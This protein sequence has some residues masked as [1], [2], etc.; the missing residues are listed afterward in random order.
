LHKKERIIMRH[1]KY[2]LTKVFIGLT[3]LLFFLNLS[4]IAVGQDQPIAKNGNWPQFRGYRATGVADAKG[5]PVVWDAT[6]GINI[7]WK[8]DIPGLGHSSPVIWGDQVFI[9]TA[10]GQDNQEPYLRVGL[11]GESPDNPEDYIH[12]YKLYCL[13]KKTGKILWEKTAVSAIP[14]VMR[15]IKGSHATPSP[16]TDGTHV[17]VFFGSQGLYCYDMKGN[18]LWEKDL[19][20]LDAGAFN[21]TNI[22]WGFGSSPIIYKERV[23]TLCDVNNQSFIAAHDIKTGEEIWKTLREEVP[24]WGTPTIVEVNGK[25]QIVVNGWHH[26]GAY[27][28]ETGEEIWKMDGGGDIPVPTPFIA[29]GMLFFSSAHGRQRPIYA[30]NPAAKGDI[31]LDEGA[32]SNEYVTW[33]NPRIGSYIPTPLVY[34]DL[35]YVL[36]DNAVLTTYN[37]KTGE[38]VYRERAGGVRGS[39]S[40]SAVAAE[41]K[42]YCPTEYGNIHV[43]EAG[44]KY[45][46]LSTNPMGEICMATPAIS[47]KTIFIRT[48]KAVYAVEDLG[49]KMTGITSS[50]AASEVD[51]EAE[52][53]SGID[54]ELLKP[55]AHELTDPT[56]ILRRT[57]AASKAVQAVSYDATLVGTGAL[58]GRAGWLSVHII[59]KGYL[60]SLPEYFIVKGKA[61]P[62]GSPDTLYFTGGTNGDKYYLT[63]HQNKSI[64]S[65][66]DFSIMGSYIRAIYGGMI[67]EYHVDEPFGA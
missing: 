52:Q 58:E 18:L 48:H 31:T 44:S 37:A 23:I 32:T 53:A 56:E 33:S 15:H 57:D 21:A 27:D 8:I 43:I 7:K 28:F 6:K 46:L 4:H 10:A 60:E 55:P 62:P 59:S 41:D 30:I 61:L 13:D 36:S 51:E 63:D 9:T 34:G 64:H 49:G 22:Q 66:F 16:A 26:R 29:H 20:Y 35:L 3:A 50:G 1:A 45:K 25:D 54:P 65:D 47:G 67:Q 2:V 40:A 39:C 11:Y 12:D 14:K 19:G 17:V 24:T 38:Q 5:L 42:I